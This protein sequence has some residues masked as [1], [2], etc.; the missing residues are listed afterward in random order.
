MLNNPWLMDRAIEVNLTKN[1]EL[2]S[3]KVLLNRP[4]YLTE[5]VTIF[6][7]LKTYLPSLEISTKPV[8]INHKQIGLM[9][10]DNLQTLDLKQCQLIGP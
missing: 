3:H 8:C 6:K 1:R 4:I 7:M 2:N 10:S 5:P 9:I